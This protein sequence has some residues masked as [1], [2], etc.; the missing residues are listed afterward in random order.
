MLITSNFLSQN[1]G[2]LPQLLSTAIQIE[3]KSVPQKSQSQKDT[4]NPADWP[5]GGKGLKN[6]KE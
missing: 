3:E 6:M 2:D 1:M 5:V 4:H